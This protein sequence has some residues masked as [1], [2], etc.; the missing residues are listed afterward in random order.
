ME[1]LPLA[2]VPW[3]A[4]DFEGAGDLPGQADVPIQAGLVQAHGVQLPEEQQLYRTFIAA[5]RPV[6]L[7]ARKVHG[8][9]DRDLDGAPELA[10]LWPTF[11]TQLQGRV[12]IAHN[13][14]VERRYLRAFPGHGFGPWID[15]LPLA[16]R[17]Y[18]QLSSHR[19]GDLVATFQLEAALEQLCP[20]L[21]WHDALYDAAAALLFLQHLIR[22]AG[23]ENQP[24]R[25]LLNR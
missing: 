18:P 20:D 1:D 3:T 11:K 6:A 23:L 4:L 2:Q 14:S 10:A 15:T 12:L 5:N 8:I 9:S 7:A 17:F 16:R 24:L 19:L 21:H 13:A 22:T 25:L